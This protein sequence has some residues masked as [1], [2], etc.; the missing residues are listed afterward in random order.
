MPSAQTA[1]EAP[2]A[3]EWRPWATFGEYAAIWLAERRSQYSTGS[4]NALRSALCAHVLPEWGNTP[5]DWISEEG[6]AELEQTLAEKPSSRGG[7]LSRSMVAKAVRIARQVLTDALGRGAAPIRKAPPANSPP[8]QKHAVPILGATGLQLLVD[9]APASWRPY[10]AFRVSSGL[11]GCEL[12]SL[13]WSQFAFERRV[14]HVET[15]TTGV[16]RV[17]P[18]S[19]GMDWALGEQLTGAAPPRAGAVFV[20]AAGRPLSAGRFDKEVWEPFLEHLGLPAYD[21]DQVQVET[22]YC[23]LGAGLTAHS[24]S[25]RTGI[26]FAEVKRHVNAFRTPAVR[27]RVWAKAFTAVVERCGPVLL[28]QWVST[29]PEDDAAARWLLKLQRSAS[30]PREQWQLCR[31]ASIGLDARMRFQLGPVDERRLPPMTNPK[32]DHWLG[33]YKEFC[34]VWS[35]RATNEI[36]ESHPYR[37]W[38][39]KQRAAYQNKSLPLWRLQHLRRIG[40]PL[41]AQR[42]ADMPTNVDQANAVVAFFREHGHYSLTQT[43]A[44]AAATKWF[45]RFCETEGTVGAQVLPPGVNSDQD[46]AAATRILF[47]QIPNFT[48]DVSSKASINAALGLT[49]NGFVPHKPV[50]VP[51]WRQQHVAPRL[52]HALPAEA[53]SAALGG[54]LPHEMLFVIGDAPVALRVRAWS[55]GSPVDLLAEAPAGLLWEGWLASPAPEEGHL[56]CDSPN[57]TRPFAAPLQPAVS[58]RLLWSRLNVHF[59]YWWADA[60]TDTVYSVDVDVVLLDQMNRAIDLGRPAHETDWG[61]WA[62]A[63][64]R[65]LMSELTTSNVTFNSNMRE[66]EDTYAAYPKTWLRYDHCARHR[67]AFVEHQVR[68]VQQGI[69]PRSHAL[70]LSQLDLS[71]GVRRQTFNALFCPTPAAGGAVHRDHCRSAARQKEERRPPMRR[72]SSW[73]ATLEAW[74]QLAGHQ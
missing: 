11:T 54:V 17:V 19:L 51:T 62:T 1:I 66:L 42:I 29:L 69:L 3:T 12:D 48:F 37:D 31:L 38:V 49:H 28:H 27:D 18:L 55:P 57:G 20:D 43:T 34:Q 14:L 40:F 36:S 32:S 30:D 5:L 45:K 68:R 9:L 21:A 58:E 4:F 60:A 56:L 73:P 63:Q 59:G 52:Q 2:R 23:L 24:V 6:C 47:D 16:P 15:A 25:Q 10:V 8:R 44:G 46:L 65:R 53:V 39:L 33:V 70:R 50:D 64:G 35:L 26:D 67:Y 72:G 41:E 22:L 13:Q 71:F 74:E 61:E 7:V